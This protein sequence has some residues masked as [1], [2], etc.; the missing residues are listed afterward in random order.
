MKSLKIEIETPNEE[1]L[2]QMLQ[3]VY[4]EITECDYKN[5]DVENNCKPIE[6]WLAVADKGRYR[7]IKE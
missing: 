3:H 7:W 1:G 6:D 4:R 2:Y 5:I